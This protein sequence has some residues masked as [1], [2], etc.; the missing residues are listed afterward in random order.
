MLSSSLSSSTAAFALPS[1]A[2]ASFRAPS[3][4]S[5]CDWRAR[6]E[7][8]SDSSCSFRL[9]ICCLD[10]LAA[11]SAAPI[12]SSASADEARAASSWSARTF[13]AVSPAAL[14]ASAAAKPA[15]TASSSAARVA[16]SLSSPAQRALRSSPSFRAANK[17]ACSAARAAWDFSRAFPA[18]SLVTFSSARASWDPASRALA[19]PASF[20]RCCTLD[21]ASRRAFCWTARS[22]WIPA[23]SFSSL[24]R[25]SF[26]EA[27]ASFH[28]S[29]SSWRMSRRLFSWL[30]VNVAAWS[31]FP[32]APSRAC[33][34]PRVSCILLSA[35]FSSVIS[36][37]VAFRVTSIDFSLSMAA[38]AASSA[39]LRASH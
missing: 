7:K 26:S 29:R 32:L 1:L 28:F 23:S 12:L 35:F 33:C 15:A 16:L 21:S 4:D 31:S 25:T 5:A 19:S 20:T 8:R 17:E 22:L 39:A 38:P 36:F 2:C 27:A 10:C 3:S 24:A 13:R 37:N 14:A 9:P 6:L 30:I 34:S 18:A 11:A